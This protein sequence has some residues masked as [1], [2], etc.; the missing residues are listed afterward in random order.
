M[1]RRSFGP[2]SDCGGNGESRFTRDEILT[3][4]FGAYSYF[5][6]AFKKSHQPGMLLAMPGN[7]RRTRLANESEEYLSKREELRSLEI[8]SMKLRGELPRHGGN[9]RQVP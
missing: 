8:E 4:D 1:D 6:S 3:C 7:M 2:G 9:F 5:S